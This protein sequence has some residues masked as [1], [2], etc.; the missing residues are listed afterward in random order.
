MSDGHATTTSV[1]KTWKK[2]DTAQIG[3]TED[4]TWK[5]V[6]VMAVDGIYAMVRIP[7]CYPFV[8]DA[9]ELRDV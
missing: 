7:Y 2:G 6:I 4:G 5:A 8:V 1:A 9:R 3:R